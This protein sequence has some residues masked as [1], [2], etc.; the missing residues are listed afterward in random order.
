MN[1]TANAG[2]SF[3]PNKTQYYYPDGT[4]RDPYIYASNGAFMP[5]K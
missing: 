5:E 2:G 3:I 4:G 1:A